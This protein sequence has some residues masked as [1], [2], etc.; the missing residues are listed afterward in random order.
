[1]AAPPRLDAG[2]AR[3]GRAALR[4]ARRGG[5]DLGEARETAG[6]LNPD[7][8]GAAVVRGLGISPGLAIG[9]VYFLENEIGEVPRRKVAAGEVEAEVG[10]LRDALREAEG[11]FR[12]QKTAS[13]ASLTEPERAIF[14]AH[15]AFYQDHLLRDS[16]EKRIREQALNAE[17][18]LKDEID[19]L[20]AIFSG[21]DRTFRERVADVRDVGNR[22]QRV[23]LR[24]QQA[25]L[26]S[27][28]SVVL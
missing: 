15:L 8:D 21:M 2:G 18:A 1:H 27:G 10:R 23:L 22:V 11:E 26:V 7:G 28:C 13:A 5:R 14:D 3:R 16:V 20:A 12:R 19:H 17:A 24:R 4:P 9:P 25:S 6:P